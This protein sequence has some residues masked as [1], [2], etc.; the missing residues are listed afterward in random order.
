MW[1]IDS[2]GG[3]SDPKA[4]ATLQKLT[5]TDLSAI[6]YYWFAEGEVAGVKCIISRTGYTGED[7]FELYHPNSG[8]LTLWNALMEAGMHGSDQAAGSLKP[9][10]GAVRS[11]WNDTPSGK[12]GP[13][14]RL[15]RSASCTTR[16]SI[17]PRW[18]Q[19][20]PAINLP[21]MR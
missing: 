1:G 14:L 15:S 21:V 16:I 4:A 18:F 6:K 2:G 7:G 19:P 5:K 12:I 10:L 13:R 8:A 3:N 17:P 9:E 20:A 11:I